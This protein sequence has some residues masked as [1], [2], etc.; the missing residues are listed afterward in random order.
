V[1]NLREE[2]I[3]FIERPFLPSIIAIFVGIAVLIYAEDRGKVLLAVTKEEF[4]SFFLNGGEIGD[5]SISS[6]FTFLGAAYHMAGRQID[7]STHFVNRWPRPILNKT[8][9]TSFLPEKHGGFEIF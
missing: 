6:F 8:H 5:F 9:H 7:M 4:I 2:G 3:T 1:H